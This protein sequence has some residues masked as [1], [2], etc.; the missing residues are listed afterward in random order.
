[1]RV[2]KYYSN[3][4]I[5]IEEAPRPKI[6]KGELLIRIEACGICGSD[7][8][9]WY[10]ID[11]VPLVLGHEVAGVVE[12]AGE[13]VVAYKKGQ[14][15]SA[16]HHVPCGSCE[17]CLNGHETVC[18]TLRKTNFDPGGFAEFVRLPEINVEKG[19]YPLPAEVSTAEATFIE[20]LAC[21]LRGQ[22]VAGMKRGFS[23]LVVGSGIA[24]LLHIA[25][26]K[27]NGAG[28]VIAT[29]I[30]E[31]RLKAAKRFGA[32]Q[33]FLAKDYNAD[34]LLKINK[35]RL[36][37]LVFICAGS[38]TAI[39]QA[40][41]SV[42][43]AGT[44]LFFAPTDKDKTISLSVNKLFWRTERKMV[45]SYA[46]SPQDHLEALELIRTGKIKV[47]DMITHSL[48]LEKIQEGFKLVVEAGNSIKV[49]IEPQK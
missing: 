37:D 8:M 16:S 15:V 10:R 17:Y 25:L 22:R 29:D 47:K 14:R 18:D 13:G 26:A 40:L 34:E 33:V 3:S 20:P 42:E 39:A 28:T 49:I 41:D 23:V 12:E 44:A 45:S 46:G 21:V 4:D 32:D 5:R 9:E 43:R 24:G 36:A 7:V 35:G 19:V 38:P 30:S 27:A 2:A 31:Y 48:P 6:G 1:M 11:R